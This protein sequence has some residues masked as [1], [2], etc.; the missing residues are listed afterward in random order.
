MKF[1]SWYLPIGLVIVLTPIYLLP[2]SESMIPSAINM[3]LPATVVDWQLQHLPASSEEIETLA[4]DTEFSKAICYKPRVGESDFISGRTL[5]DRLDLS[6]V[7]SGHDLNNSIHRPERCMP[8]QGHTINHT[9]DLEIAI[10]KKHKIKSRRLLSTQTI[11]L[12][13]ERTEFHNFDCVTYYFFVGNK[14]ITHDHYARTFLDMKDRLLLGLD[15]RWA[16]VSVS[17]WYGD[18][19]WMQK[20]IHLEEA[21]SKIQK[22]ISELA[23]VQIDWE[24]LR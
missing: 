21:D 14:H 6:V 23:K 16:Y 11:P 18:L 2:E 19:P 5:V 17:M 9:S 3:K 8:S 1:H 4:P 13:A 20:K 12:N 22:F 10:S 7:L 15:Q 24:M